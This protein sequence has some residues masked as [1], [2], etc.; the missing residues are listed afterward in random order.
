MQVPSKL[1]RNDGASSAGVYC[2]PHLP[3]NPTPLLPQQPKSSPYHLHLVVA[4][5]DVPT[6]VYGTYTTHAHAG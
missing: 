5:A 3:V 4:L 1:K 2:A 6:Q